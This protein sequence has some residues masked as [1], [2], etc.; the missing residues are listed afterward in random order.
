[1]YGTWHGTDSSTGFSRN[2]VLLVYNN[3][4]A[5]GRPGIF[6]RY[7]VPN[8]P[9]NPDIKW[10][11]SDYFVCGSQ[12]CLTNDYTRN[13]VIDPDNE[14][15]KDIPVDASGYIRFNSTTNLSF[16]STSYRCVYTGDDDGDGIADCPRKIKREDLIKELKSPGYMWTGYANTMG[17]NNVKDDQPV[18]FVSA[19]WKNIQPFYNLHLLSNAGDSNKYRPSWKYCTYPLNST[20][21]LNEG[22]AIGK[23]SASG[24]FPAANRWWGTEGEKIIFTVTTDNSS[25]SYNKTGITIDK[26]R[27][28]FSDTCGDTDTTCWNEEVLDSPIITPRISTDGTDC[29]T[30]DPNTSSSVCKIPSYYNTD[31]IFKKTGAR[32]IQ[33]HFSFFEMEDRYDI[34]ML[35]TE[36]QWHMNRRLDATNQ[37]ISEIIQEKPEVPWSVA[38]Y[39]GFA[40]NGTLD[41]GAIILSGLKSNN[42]TSHMNSLT[43]LY[44]S[45]YTPTGE[46]LVKAWDYLYNNNKLLWSCRD[47]HIV[48]V[49]DG[50]P[51]DDH[52]KNYLL[53]NNTADC[54]YDSL[55]PL[56]LNTGCNGAP[57]YQS[58]FNSFLNN[59]N[60]DMH[61]NNMEGAADY[62]YSQHGVDLYHTVH[63]GDTLT[64]HQL[65]NRLIVNAI[66]FG[67]D[68]KRLEDVSDYGNG[69]YYSVGNS[70]QIKEAIKQVVISAID[71]NAVASAAPA[72]NVVEQEDGK[73]YSGNTVYI[74]MFKPRTPGHWW[75]NIKKFC[76]INKQD[77]DNCLKLDQDLDGDKQLDDN[78]GTILEL[79]SGDTKNPD[80]ISENG[81]N[82]LVIAQL[83]ASKRSI[84]IPK[85][86]AGETD[87]KFQ[88][89]LDSDI[90]DKE[91]LDFMKGI[92]DPVFDTSVPLFN[93]RRMLWEI[94]ITHHHFSSEIG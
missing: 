31:I 29:S 88:P 41:E 92:R 70:Q 12:N 1:M 44:A 56:L 53:G 23:K 60:A 58:D 38:K 24:S 72:V 42:P 50:Y 64:D 37:A 13:W 80:I 90:S 17:T 74:P 34:V 57:G 89:M 16:P 71:R 87:L 75:G 2:H 54:N 83:S 15:T 63:D 76:L 25:I 10:S 68:V 33:A 35:R 66:S 4:D 8:D 45:G 47:N 51:T 43:S 21:S 61:P 30:L 67:Y 69:E 32:K 79:F 26:W 59:N 19:N 18:F 7:G 86:K 94:S 6:E 78:P 85:T 52:P 48:I 20:I 14:T 62:L 65:G 5:N 27:Y 28:T 40:D 91:I 84:Y 39:P 9:G 93:F 77:T 3:T 82:E 81:I 55:S 22:K 36:N 73:Q 49:S 11:S 46:S